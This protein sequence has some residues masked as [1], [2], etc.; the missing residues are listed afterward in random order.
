VAAP[1]VSRIR[2]RYQEC[3]PQGVVFNANYFAYFDMAL[4]EAWRVLFEG[5]YV[6]MVEGGVDCV[7]AEA[8][9]RFRGGARFDDELDLRWWVTSLGNTSMGTRVD[10]VR[11]GETLVEGN[12]RHV[13]VRAGST[14]KI[15][16]PPAIRAGLA[17]HVL[18]AE[19]PV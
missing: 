2:V 8:G 19:A 7:V 5:G 17:P 14:D 11:D 13:F 6:A 1:I 18:A 12:L 4:T 9:A 16:I 15:E 3:D 10:V